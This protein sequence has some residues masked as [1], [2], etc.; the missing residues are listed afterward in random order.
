MK[1]HEY[2]FIESIHFFHQVISCSLMVKMILLVK[3]NP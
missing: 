1:E 2:T 3:C